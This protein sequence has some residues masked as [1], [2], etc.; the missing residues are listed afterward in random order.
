MA[1]ATTRQAAPHYEIGVLSKALDIFDTL[2]TRTDGASLT[3]IAAILK[4]SKPTVFR[5]LRTL[6]IRGYVERADRSRY[7]LTRKVMASAS[8]D[9]TLDALIEAAP[10]VM[11]RLVDLHHETVNLGILDGGEIVVVKAIES[12]LVIRASSK[13]GNRRHVHSTALGK[14][15]VAWKT[16]EEVHRLV[17]LKGLPPLTHK[18]ITSLPAFRKEL[19]KVRKRG[20][21]CDSEENELHGACLAAPI[22][23]RTGDIVAAISISGPANRMT[24]RKIRAVQPDLTQAAQELSARL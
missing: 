5:I 8:P 13:A 9:E 16:P 17:L 23:S 11:Q 19:A 12:P 4:Y 22:R 18:T 1:R 14:V 20:L 15:L 6:D 3:E 10:P 24:A 21:A 2:R 7:R